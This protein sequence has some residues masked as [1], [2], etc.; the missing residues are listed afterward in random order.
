VDVYVNNTG[1]QEGNFTLLCTF[2]GDTASDN[3]TIA[4]GEEAMYSF[5]LNTTGLTE[6]N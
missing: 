3:A 5:V 6:G 1:A 2:E 4:V